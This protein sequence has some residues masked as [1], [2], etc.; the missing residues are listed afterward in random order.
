[1]VRLKQA[2]KVADGFSLLSL[3]RR[4]SAGEVVRPQNRV[5]F[6]PIGRIGKD[7]ISCIE[8]QKLENQACQYQW[9]REMVAMPVG[10]IVT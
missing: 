6:F 4:R 9:S 7:I 10:T 2:E 5:K 1:M 8:R 3:K